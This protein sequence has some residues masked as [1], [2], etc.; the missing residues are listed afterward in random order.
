MLE[1]YYT[2]MQKFVTCDAGTEF[3]GDYT[4]KVLEKLEAEL[5]LACPDTPQQ[6]GVTE[7][8]KERCEG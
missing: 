3:T 2:K 7:R 4:T 1:T 5:Q 6:I 8:F